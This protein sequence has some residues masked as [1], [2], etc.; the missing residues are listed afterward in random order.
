MKPRIPISK[1]RDLPGGS[2]RFSDTEW[3][4]IVERLLDR[5]K[6]T[7]EHNSCPCVACNETRR[8]VL[9]METIHGD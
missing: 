2:G 8:N 6:T 3:A 9:G 7:V 4:R 1:P 5:L